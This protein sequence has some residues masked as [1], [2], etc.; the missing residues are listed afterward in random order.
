[1]GVS[2]QRTPQPPMRPS[3]R[4][5]FDA[6]PPQVVTR[7]S[8]VSSKVDTLRAAQDSV[9]A[10]VSALQAKVDQANALAE[11]R[12]TNTRVQDLISGARSEGAGRDW[13]VGPW[14]P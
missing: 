12:A 6:R 10:Q 3:L 7:L 5:P 1:M 14:R 11:A 13:G 4:A 9:A 8:A 2:W